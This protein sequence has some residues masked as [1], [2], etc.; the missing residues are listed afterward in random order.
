MIAR[1]TGTL[2]ALG[3]DSLIV[4]VHGVGYRIY[5]STETISGLPSAGETVSFWTYLAVR[6]TALDLYGFNT[7]DELQLF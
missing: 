4:D 1:L 3:T 7:Q 5:T 6:E 2:S